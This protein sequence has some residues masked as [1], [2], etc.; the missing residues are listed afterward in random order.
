MLCMHEP[1]LVK[2]QALNVDQQLLLED[3]PGEA[4][5]LSLT[6]KG[7]AKMA[8]LKMPRTVSSKLLGMRTPMDIR[9]RNV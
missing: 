4:H 5:L 8:R 3:E 2:V 6:S 1:M 9:R 7:P